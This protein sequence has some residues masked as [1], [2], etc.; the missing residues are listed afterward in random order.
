VPLHRPRRFPLNGSLL[1]SFTLTAAV[2]AFLWLPPLWLYGTALWDVLRLQPARWSETLPLRPVQQRLFINTLT[3]AFLTAGL[4][5]TFGLPTALWLARGHRFWR[6]PGLFLCALPLALPPTLGATAWLE[7]TRTPPA[8]SLASL[9]A[10]RPAPLAPIAIAA[11]VLA[12][13]FFPIVVF[14]VYAALHAIPAQ[15]EEAARLYDSEWGVWR[16]VTWPLLAPAVYG[17]AG[18]VMALA[19]WEM[20]APDLLDA[21]TYSVQIYRDLNAPD[22]LDPQGKAVKAALAGVP[23]LALGIFA[24]WPAA[25][26]LHF[27]E[28]RVF[29]AG[30]EHDP[31][32]EE[33]TLAGRAMTPLA[34]LVL[35]ASPL[36]P[37][38]IFFSQLKPISVLRDV[39]ESNSREI[40]NTAGLAT[41][42]A[43]GITGLGFVLVALWRAWPSFFSHARRLALWLTVAPLLIAPMMLAVALIHFWNRPQ[44]ALIYGGLP[45]TG[46]TLVDWFLDNT[47]RYGM[48]L[49]G[50]MARFLPLAVLLLHEA[51]RR[52]DDDLIASAR[53]LGATPTG[54]ARTVLAPLLAPS[55]LGV[56]VLVWALCA[57]ELSTSVLVNAPGGQTL[58]VPIFNLMHIGSQAEVAALS[59][60]LAAMS[61]AV[62]LV[63]ALALWLWRRQ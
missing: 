17:A 62:L 50:Y 13:C 41:V 23:M 5:V 48:M 29:N 52:V 6:L 1:L 63:A 35:A 16:R 46:N 7:I 18:I 15:V 30:A 31:A 36:A 8:R 39:V 28:K 34:L 27:Y 38:L 33:V 44:F 37:L 10:D 20:G 42:A 45:E 57:G 4:A 24:L 22:D 61:G 60:I 58:P 47:A 51:A 2:I 54:A 12:L 59:L 19:M 43:L 40:M 25:R 32:S 3:L 9:A 53:N 14:A 11:F 49:I 56:G 26:A 21:R 55:L